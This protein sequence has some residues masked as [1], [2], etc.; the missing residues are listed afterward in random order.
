[1]NKEDDEETYKSLKPFKELAD[2]LKTVEE[3][4]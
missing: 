2:F 4:G 1:M 3:G